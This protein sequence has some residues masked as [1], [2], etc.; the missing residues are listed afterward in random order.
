M[1][2]G[3]WIVTA[4]AGLACSWIVSPPTNT[5]GRAA[6]AAL[7]IGF[8]ASCGLLTF[9]H[10]AVLVVALPI[11]AV[12]APLAVLRRHRAGRGTLEPAAVRGRVRMA[13]IGGMLFAFG[14]NVA[15]LNAEARW[16]WPVILLGAAIVA[17]ALPFH[18]PTT[19]TLRAAPADIRAPAV[20]L[21][22]PALWMAVAKWTP[23]Q[24]GGG[25]SATLPLLTLWLGAFLI[26]SRG[27][28]PRLCAA[29]LL[30]AT[31]QVTTTAAL[32]PAEAAT[33][34][35][36]VS[37]P[38][39][40]VVLLLSKLERA[41]NTRDFLELGGLASRA[42]RLSVALLAVVFW[43]AGTAAAVPARTLIELALAGRPLGSAWQAVREMWPVLVPHA[44]AVWGWTIVLRDLLVGPARSPLFPEPL[45][46][47]VTMPAAE[48]PLEDLTATELAAIAGCAA[49][50]VVL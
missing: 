33:V 36:A 46:D 26:L 11:A 27:D 22:G 14:V 41:A 9:E 31:G 12:A 50:A 24:A 34:A 23:S 7:C 44:I 38:L 10:R 37:T 21:L 8:L 15:V 43:L 49:I 45:R 13:V 39:V 25:V 28:L 6:W 18:R 40:L 5:A 2:A 30:F 32:N 35:G 1:T 4:V 16:T 20:L 42:P 47:R 48:R 29:A 19:E 17:G 3:A